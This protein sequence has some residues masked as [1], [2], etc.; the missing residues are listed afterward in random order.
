MSH[1]HEAGFNQ[2]ITDDAPGQLRSRL[3]TSENAGQLGLGHLVHQAPESA[4]RG[5]WRGSGF[6]LRT[7]G[8]LAVRAGEGML[9]S[10]TARPNGQ[11]TQMDVAETTSQLKA[12]AET[13]K[14]LSDAAR[15]QTALPL[16]AN[17]AQTAFIKAIDPQQD[18]QHQSRVGGQEAR[19]AIPG[20]R[21]PGDPTERFAKPFIVNEAPSDIGLSSPASTLLFAGGHLHATVQQDLHVASGHT[22]A[23]AVGEGASWFSHSGGI[24]SIAQA[25]SHTVQAHTDQLEILADQSLT[26]TSSNDEIHLLAKEKIV[27]QAGQSSVT[28]E[29]S[30]INFACPGKFSVKGSGIAFLGAAK[31]LAELETL[32]EGKV[33]TLVTNQLMETAGRNFD[34]QFVLKDSR[35]EPLRDIYY[36]AKLPTG[37]LVHGETDLNGCTRRFFTVNASQV[38]I[39]LGHIKSL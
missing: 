7:D 2:W 13:A 19:K 20:S 34:E 3:A 24:R 28:L 17:A 36:T 37:E 1:N 30:N 8:W 4:T 27:L 21:D 23:S 9:I 33:A 12:A 39:Y 32:P 38:E 10:A 35:G 16:K 31:S 29:G 26:V 15:Q 11:S 22:I 25:G 18:G 14:A 5:A 6:E